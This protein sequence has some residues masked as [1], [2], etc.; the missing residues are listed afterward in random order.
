MD[1]KWRALLIVCVGIFMLLLDITV[2]NVAL[3]NIQKELAHLLYRPPMGGRCLRPSPRHLHAEAGTLGDWLGRKRVF[4]SGVAVFTS[5]PRSAARRPLRS[6][7]TSRA[8]SRASAARSMF[9]SRSRSSPR[10]SRG[11]SAAPPSGS[12]ARRSGSPSRSARSSAALLTEYAGWRWIFFVNLPIGAFCVFGALVYLHESRD[13]QHRGFDLARLRAPHRRSLR[14]RPRAAARPRLGLG[15]RHDR[16]PLRRRAS[17][18]SPRSSSR[19][20]TSR[21]R[22]ST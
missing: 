13:E 3:P 19:S 7:S 9:R 6:S 18:C 11:A 21:K 1:R 20:W 2:V 4:I 14:A 17:S 8:G 16:R 15:Q 5:P 10:S 12:G 22:C